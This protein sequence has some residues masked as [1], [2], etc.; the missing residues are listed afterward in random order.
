MVLQFHDPAACF[1]TIEI[2]VIVDPGH[3]VEIVRIHFID[4]PGFQHTRIADHH[5]QAT[6]LQDGFIHCMFHRFQVWSHQSA[7]T[8]PGWE[9]CFYSIQLTTCPAGLLINIQQSPHWL[10]PAKRNLAMP[11]PYPMAP[12]VMAT[13]LL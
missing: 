9:M 4:S 13:T 2:A 5:I 8:M 6:E 12:P 10:L 11:S 1:Y 7:Q 3:K